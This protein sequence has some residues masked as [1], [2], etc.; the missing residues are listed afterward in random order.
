MHYIVLEGDGEDAAATG[1][2]DVTDDLIVEGVD[3]HTTIVEAQ[4]YDRVFDVAENVSLTLSDVTVRGGR[5]GSVIESD[6]GGGLRAADG[7]FVVLSRAIF[8]D[9]AVLQGGGGVGLLGGT[10]SGAV[11]LAVESTFRRNS[12]GVSPDYPGAGGAIQA[13][14][15]ASI[16]LLDGSLDANVAE[17]GAAIDSALGA[18]TIERSTIAAH[19]SEYDTFRIRNTEPVR[20]ENSTITDNASDLSIWSAA[21]S[22]TTT[23]QNTTIT[24]NAARIAVI[25]FYPSFADLRLRNTVLF[26]AVTEAECMAVESLGH[27]AIAAGSPGSCTTWDATDLLV[28][29]PLLGTLGDNGGATPTRMPLAGSP[30]RDA[31]DD[32]SCPAL[33]QRRVERP[34][35]GDGNGVARCDIGAVEVPEPGWLG[36]AAAIA[37]LAFCARSDSST[38]RRQRRA[39]LLRAE[40]IAASPKSRNTICW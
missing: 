14:G 37:A 18:V 11:L 32:A 4:A 36:I 39:V 17:L 12:A 10:S 26:N 31:G 3:A 30:L 33:D 29:D 21:G 24:G 23:F 34:Q 7:A 16:Y 8:E 13:T 35:D 19:R 6:V 9:N 2:L 1:D 38:R 20:V 15:H 27:N 40:A 22:A 5:R 28:A 25:N